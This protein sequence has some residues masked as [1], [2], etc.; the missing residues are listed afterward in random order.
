[1][2]VLKR[3]QS[4]ASLLSGVPY[5]GVMNVDQS[6]LGSIF[7]S[8]VTVDSRQV[9]PGTLF[10]ALPGVG[11]DGHSFVE[12]AVNC[13]AR[14]I[15]GLTGRLRGKATQYPEVIFV[16]VG[17]TYAAYAIISANYF[18]NPGSKLT[19]AAVT[20]TNGK[21]TVT[22]IV[23]D[24]L[25]EAGLSVGVVG[26][27][28]NRYTT[29]DGKTTFLPTR[30]T[31]PEAYSLQ[32]VLKEMVDHDV[33]FVIMEVSSH[34]LA[35]SRVGGLM[36]Q[37]A[38]FTNLSMDHLDYHQGMDD[39]FQAKMRIFRDHLQKNATAVLPQE[40]DENGIGE[41]LEQ[42]Y[43][44]CSETDVPVINWGAK[45][46][47]D[48]KLCSHNSSLEKTAM[49]IEIQGRKRLVETF[50]VG[51]YNI[52]NILTSMGLC[53]ALGI[54]T[55]SIVDGVGK[56]TGAPGRLE[57]VVAE[58]WRASGPTV[59]VDYAHTPDAL[60]KVLSTAKELPH[61]ELF[62]VFGCG[63]DRDTGKRAVMG[64]IGARLCGVSIVTDDN[65]RTEDPDTIVSQVVAGV[66]ATG[67]QVYPRQ[68]LDSRKVHDVGCVVIRDRHEA[69]QT[70]IENAKAGDIVVIAGKGHEPYQLTIKGKKYFD[71]RMQA[72]DA[73]LSWTVPL[74][75]EAV[76]GECA[77][78]VDSIS[79]LGP[80]VT[81]SRLKTKNGIFVALRGENHD[82][83]A[84]AEQAVASGARCL[85]VDHLVSD[86][87]ADITQIIVADTLKALG[88]LAGFRRHRLSQ[89]CEQL[90][91]GLTGSCGKTTVKEMIAAILK[92]KY[93]AGEDH[94]G[95]A[96]LK[97][98]GNFNNLIGLPLSLLPLGVHNRIAVL[99]MGMNIPGE[100]KRLTE[101]A[102][103]D[104]SCITNIYGAHLLG[105]GSV[106]GVADA[107]EELFQNTK[108]SGVLIVN[109]DDERVA[110]RSVKYT[111]K[112]ITFGVQCVSKGLLPDLWA[113][114]VSLIEGGTISFTLHFGE[115]TQDIHLYIAG[116]HNVTNALCAAAT[117]IAAGCTLTE[118]AL[119]LA[120]FRAPDKR[121][122]L[123]P[124][125]FGFEIL[126]DTYNA[127]PA[128]MEAGLK[129]L[130]H[131]G[132]GRKI[133][134]LGDMLEL[135]AG[136]AKAHYEI[137][138]CA[139]GLGLDFV[140]SYGEYSSE[141]ARGMTENGCDQSKVITVR[142]KE[143][144]TDYLENKI[145]SGLLGEGDL[146]LFKASRGLRFET[147][148]DCF[149]Q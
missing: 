74:L 28:N 138:K 90:V 104:I 27:V 15:V 66:V 112:K 142:Q 71:D 97:T 52:E 38:A 85:V 125:K 134:V 149:K 128:S 95:N 136:A 7:V 64:G 56:T 109:L 65:P 143:E 137:G 42:L 117:S 10:I 99:E 72:K 70:A 36:F 93:P 144:V 148:V 123:L 2:T 40:S 77:T 58:S 44:Y 3:D 103:P 76:A 49:E 16:E 84:Y 20:G 88:D 101:I 146:V 50:L 124:S 113:S 47:V 106:E 110:D 29:R 57:R 92:R 105:L 78:T 30:F 45:N 116:E 121:M 22:Y 9:T 53:I 118:V 41:K 32:Q 141:V 1:M 75:V 115:D 62:G 4:F 17:D 31:T 82:A 46:G 21:T 6:D 60:E 100:I 14:I 91:I 108:K 89:E 135:G 55:D 120:D 119:G 130:V 132:R 80:V 63:G 67:T 19:L 111:Q 73:I 59:F 54:D 5:T 8:E 26:T 131:I 68:W 107:K 81:D 98:E 33:K 48:I 127:N 39:Y 34:A 11:V 13:G 83:H 133:A 79:L 126:N 122:E 61:N 18:D 24:I 114:D 140:I 12:Q 94:P 37:V 69:I 102:D 129:A 23:E 145:D 96:V 35:Q 139:A 86:V 87:D 43:R 51:Y 25:K 147:I